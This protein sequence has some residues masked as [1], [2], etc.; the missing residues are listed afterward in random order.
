MRRAHMEIRCVVVVSERARAGQ[1][2]LS[3]IKLCRASLHCQ[4]PPVFGT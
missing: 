1:D 4:N 3:H 2:G